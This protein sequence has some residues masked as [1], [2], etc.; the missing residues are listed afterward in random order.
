MNLS[1]DYVIVQKVN[2]VSTV[3]PIIYFKILFFGHQSS[4]ILKN[5]LRLGKNN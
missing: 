2:D 1:T 4:D 3:E 5:G